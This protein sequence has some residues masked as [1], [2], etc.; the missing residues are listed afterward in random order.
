MIRRL[1]VTAG[2]RVHPFDLRLHTSQTHGHF[3]R[4]VGQAVAG[5][6]WEGAW[7]ARGWEGTEV[8]RGRAGTGVGSG[9]GGTYVPQVGAGGAAS[10]GLRLGRGRAAAS[11]DDPPP[12]VSTATSRPAATMVPASAATP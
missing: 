3:F 1:S 11:P 6:E 5:L 9:R 7:V 8:T 2:T 12:A 4:L 10:T